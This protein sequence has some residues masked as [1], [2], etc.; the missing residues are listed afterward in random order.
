M[1]VID[2]LQE[3]TPPRCA[4][5][6]SWHPWL[7]RWNLPASNLSAKTRAEASES[8]K[9]SCRAW[10]VWMTSNSYAPGGPT[11]VTSSVV[12]P[13]TSP[14]WRRS[15]NVVVGLNSSEIVPPPKK[16][17]GG[18]SAFDPVLRKTLFDVLL[19]RSKTPFTSRYAVH[20]GPLRLTVAPLSIVTMSKPSIPDVFAMAPDLNCAVFPPRPP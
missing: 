7:S 11:S 1:S 14:R 18:L 5:V 8:A 16:V 9:L 4:A 19:L 2:P 13:C 12:C 3:K 10:D 20:S 6:Y 15:P 17:P